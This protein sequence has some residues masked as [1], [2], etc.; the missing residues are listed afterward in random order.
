MSTLPIAEVDEENISDKQ[1]QYDNV[2]NIPVPDYGNVPPEQQ[3]I[4]TYGKFVEVH[5][6]E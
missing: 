4:S 2:E 1:N 3:P 6:K 5:D